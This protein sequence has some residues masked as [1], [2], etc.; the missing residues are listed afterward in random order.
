MEQL[1]QLQQLVHGTIDPAMNA[2][3]SGVVASKIAYMLAILTRSA[4]IWSYNI[5]KSI[6]SYSLKAFAIVGDL[7]KT[8]VL[9]IHSYQ[10]EFT[11][12]SKMIIDKTFY[13]HT[14][15]RY[16]QGSTQKIKKFHLII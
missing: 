1:L 11:Y 5:T 12:N 9:D 3:V 10:T 8:S 13:E 15:R 6:S 7:V 2:A 16:L 4:R 14:A